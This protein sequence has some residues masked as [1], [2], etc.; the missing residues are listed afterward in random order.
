METLL[1]VPVDD[2]VVFPNMTVTLTIDVG[3]EERVLLVPREDGEFASVGTVAE[4]SEHVRLPGGGHAVALAG[5]HRGIAGAAHTDASGDLRVEVT[6]HPDDEPTDGRTRELEREYRAVVEE[7]LELR[8]DDGRIAAFV[9]SITEPGTLAD[10]SGY[11]PDLTYEQKVELLATL[12]VTERL[13]LALRLQ[14]ERLTELQVRKQIRED[15][16]SGAEKQQRDYFL[17]K[18]MD[19]IR[20]ELGEDDASVI[21][22]YRTKIEESGMPEAVR[23]QAEKELGRLERMGEQSGESSMIRTYLDWL[24]AVPWGERSEDQ[25]DPVDAR[26]VLD[27]DHAGLEDVKDRIEEHIGVLKLRRERGLD[28]GE[29]DK[30]SKRA[31]GTILTLI[32]PPGTGKTSIGES[33]ARATGRE[34]VR[35]SLGG[36]RDEAE[37]RG[38]RRTYIGALPGRLVRALR[39]AGTMNPVILLDEVD[40]VGADWRDDPSAALLEVLDPAQNHSFRDHYLDVELDLSQVMFI[41]TANMADTIPAPLLDRMEV[42]RFDGYTTDEK[43]AIGRDYLWPRQRER[44]GLREDEVAVGDEVIRTVIAEYTREAGVRGLERELGTILRKTATKIASGKATAPVTVDLDTVRDALG[45]QKF[46]Q[47]SAERTAVP[48]VATGLAV[49][50]AGGDVL[51]VEATGM[52]GKN[53]LVLTGQLGDVMK[54]SARIALSYA[55]GNAEKLGID[56]DVFDGREFHVHVPAGAIPKDGPSA[57]ITMTT[58]LASLLSGRPVKHT[59]G[60]TG[61]VTL[62]GRVLPIGGLKQKV[63]AAHAAGLTDVILPER[64]RGDLDDV[65]EDVREQMAFHPVM[66]IDEVLDIALE[67]ARSGV[68]ATA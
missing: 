15:V 36:V 68:Q 63:L 52:K 17:R 65:P 60:M 48:G 8:G 45:R 26:E 24:I 27:A 25:L 34:F 53:D 56:E 61:E 2:S 22:E 3:D 59:V 10:T 38:H 42:V 40:K 28:D 1:L 4:V 14:R 57:G 13:D 46:F 67:P 58:A 62:Q 9:R 5:L 7:I 55:R 51:F 18:Q 19:S 54:E 30:S 16:Q 21:D 47:E 11:A 33:I 43:V 23:E 32:G 50:G 49:T 66:T 20:K 37:I 31:A 64:N 6:P 44:N 39:D 41:A 29:Q 35:M 12:D